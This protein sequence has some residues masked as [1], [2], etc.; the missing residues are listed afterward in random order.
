MKKIAAVFFVAVVLAAAAFGLWFFWQRSIQ[1]V[2]TEAQEREALMEQ[3]IQDIIN[4]SATEKNGL[5]SKIE[6]LNQQIA[7]MLVE[8]DV[9]FDAEP[10]KEQ[11]L[12]IGELATVTY[13]YTNVGTLDSTKQIKG[14]GWT[15][16]FSKK[17]IVVSMDGSLKAGIDVNKVSIKTD[18]ATKTITVTIPK[19]TILSNELDETSLVVH[20][21]DE[22]LF[23]N[24]TLEDG[25]SVRSEI[26]SKAEAK[27][28][29][30][31]LLDEARNKAGD[32]IRNLI[33]AVPYVKDTYKIVIK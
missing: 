4:E 23:S 33:E 6:S 3:R 27:A 11:I 5:L 29:E 21:E 12:E 7:D 10:I 20:V 24:I 17:T 9:V 30:Y 13:C 1:Q 19:A 18:E 32:I 8:E 16:P 15:V 31:G 28:I 2:Q 25:S 26:K 22:K 14:I